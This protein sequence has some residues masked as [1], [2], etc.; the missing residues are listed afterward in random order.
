MNKTQEAKNNTIHIVNDYL[1]EDAN[2]ALI[3]SWDTMKDDVE[4]Y[5]ANVSALDIQI[6]IS[7]TDFTG[8]TTNQTEAKATLAKYVANMI[9]APS[10]RYARNKGDN[11]LL[12]FFK[13]SEYQLK[14]YALSGITQLAGSIIS[15][16]DD[17]LHN[18]PE[19]ASSTGIVAENI[20]T[21]NGY[22]DALTA[23]LGQ[24]KLMQRAVDRSLAEIDSI[25]K[26]IWDFDFPNL[27]DDSHHFDETNPDFSKGLIDA[28][29]MDELPTEHTG[30]NGFV[31]DA[32]GNVIIG[33]SV[34]NLD[35]P[36]R[37]PM[38]TDNLGYYHDDTF[39]WN[40][41]RYKYS[42]PNFVDQVVTVKIPRG[43]KVVQNVIMV[44]K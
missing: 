36:D 34:T 4:K 44:K 42:H 14:R 12:V 3:Q 13:H 27:I 2:K 22:N 18:V 11:D 25:Q 6:A 26:L 38:L 41:Y 16:S 24:A 43:R 7:Q 23:L 28:I 21:A 39:K 32:D 8:I 33:C 15:K 19:Y 30:I 10:C 29:K 20:T 17:M 37:K 40:T 9:C 1:K 5:F 35:L 31:H